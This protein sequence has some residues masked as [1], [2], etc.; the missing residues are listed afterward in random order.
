MTRYELKDKDKQAKYLAVFPDFLT[1]LTNA[2][3]HRDPETRW[4]SVQSAEYEYSVNVYPEEV[5]TFA[6][7]DPHAWNNFPEVKPPEGVL[8]RLEV[9]EA[10]WDDGLEGERLC[11]I[12]EVHTF[13]V[14]NDDQKTESE[15][16]EGRWYREYRGKSDEMLNTYGF[17]PDGKIFKARFRPWDDEEAAK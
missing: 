15:I 1:A 3:N 2:M 10:S 7:Y 8:M 5:E 17:P 13:T 11:A 9:V 6:E 16:T 4:I 12:W 14:I